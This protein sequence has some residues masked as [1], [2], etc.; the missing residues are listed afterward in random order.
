MRA[1]T[2]LLS[3][4][5]NLLDDLNLHNVLEMPRKVPLVD[6]DRLIWDLQ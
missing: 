4:Q 5:I 3:Y 2:W 6:I 1:R